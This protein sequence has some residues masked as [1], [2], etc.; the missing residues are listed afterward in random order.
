MFYEGFDTSVADTTQNSGGAER[1]LR[2]YGPWGE[3]T[4]SN[5]P[6]RTAAGMNRW[7][8]V[9]VCAGSNG[10][11]SCNLTRMYQMGP[12]MYDA[13]LGRFLQRDPLVL[14]RSAARVN[15]YQ[16]AWNDPIS[17]GD[18]SGYDPM[19]WIR[20]TLTP[21]GSSSSGG[22]SLMGGFLTNLAVSV[23]QAMLDNRQN[24]STDLLYST[25]RSDI[26]PD[27][28]HAQVIAMVGVA[29]GSNPTQAQIARARNN[30][31]EQVIQRLWSM[32]RYQ[33]FRGDLV[34]KVPQATLEFA[35][36]SVAGAAAVKG[37]V[38]LAPAVNAWGG[39]TVTAAKAWGSTVTW[40]GASNAT[41]YAIGMWKFAVA[42][43]P[44]EYMDAAW[45][46][47]GP[48]KLVKNPLVGDVVGG[49]L[50]YIACATKD[51]G[52]PHCAVDAAWAATG[53]GMKGLARVQT[54]HPKSL[55]PHA[56][57]AAR[58]AKIGI[59]NDVGAEVWGQVGD[60]LMPGGKE[61]PEWVTVE[62][63]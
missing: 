15:P 62:K 35:A 51:G 3:S 39:G 63:P 5:E 48:L 52:G 44:A 28:T 13:G 34:A 24:S 14:P 12:R 27:G 54:M 59:V 60:P 42:E 19:L 20:Q 46:M 58:E 10:A 55:L 37:V 9:D 21:S 7:H 4:E 22:S 61:D 23:G 33:Q 41:G 47:A 2:A 18:P 36:L 45:A 6:D 26:L 8:G 32:G 49:V 11:T 43:T 17:Y 29:P 40:Q 53:A 1:A 56:A 25:S 50:G 30:I 38:V 31:N 16:Y 57:N